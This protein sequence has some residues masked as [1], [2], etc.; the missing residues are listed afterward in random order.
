M[1]EITS[2]MDCSM[3]CLICG[4]TLKKLSVSNS[5]P[6]EDMWRE[7][8]VHRISGGFGSRHDMTEFVIGICDD[9][10]DLKIEDGK[11]ELEKD[12][13]PYF[14]IRPSDKSSCFDD[15][16]SIVTFYGPGTDEELL[17]NF[18]DVM[19]LYNLS[20]NQTSI[21]FARP[22]VSVSNSQ[23]LIIRAVLSSAG[24]KEKR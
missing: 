11:L 10:I 21:M 5:P 24:W 16:L 18:K 20:H 14:R 23:L 13:C 9:C 15:D 22:V 2:G 12:T 1:K 8:I 4:K 19:D 17:Q 7:A 3:K 6:E